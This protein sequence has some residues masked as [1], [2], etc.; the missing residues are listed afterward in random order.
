MKYAIFVDGHIT[1]RWDD[2]AQADAICKLAK[3]GARI[4]K[5]GHVYEVRE[6]PDKCPS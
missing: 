6:V 5:S 3:E 2:R 1:C 4:N